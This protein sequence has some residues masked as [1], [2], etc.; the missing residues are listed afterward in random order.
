MS[1]MMLSV[2]FFLGFSW[3]LKPI[4]NSCT[5]KILLRNTSEEGTQLYLPHQCT[6]I[7]ARFESVPL[8]KLSNFRWLQNNLKNA[9]RAGLKTA[10][11]SVLPQHTLL[12]DVGT[13]VRPEFGHCSHCILQSSQAGSISST[14]GNLQRTPGT[15]TSSHTVWGQ[16]AT[17]IHPSTQPLSAGQENE[18]LPNL[19]AEQFEGFNTFIV[20]SCCAICV[21][22]GFVPSEGHWNAGQ[23][24]S[25][26]RWICAEENFG[27][28][29]HHKGYY[30][31]PI[32]FSFFFIFFFCYNFTYANIHK[33]K[34]RFIKW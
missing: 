16:C 7:A 11:I 24:C 26:C 23:R 5:Y 3:Q 17:L 27:Q 31:V 2:M 4:H 34:W 6:G 8:K 15:P 9:S 20:V 28:F 1:N 29:F 21:T 30:N 33:R 12:P 13:K 18:S 22:L 14:R 25:S 10:S 32:F 19:E